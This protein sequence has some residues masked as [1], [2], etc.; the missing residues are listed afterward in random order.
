MVWAGVVAGVCRLGWLGVRLRGPAVARRR[1]LSGPG[2]RWI[3]G[4]TGAAQVT[5]KAGD[6]PTPLRMAQGETQ[7]LEALTTQLQL[8][9]GQLQQLEGQLAEQRQ[10][11]QATQQQAQR[12]AASSSEASTKYEKQL[13]AQRQQLVQYD[14]AVYQLV[15]RALPCRLAPR[16]WRLVLGP[17]PCWPRLESKAASGR[18]LGCSRQAPPAGRRRKAAGS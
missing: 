14:T 18:L 8:R 1:Q 6:R 2:R 3:T 5:H 16:A 9:D 12:V 7:Q 13:A 4:A 11:V 15:R 10:E 17:S